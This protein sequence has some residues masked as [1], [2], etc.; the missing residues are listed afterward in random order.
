MYILISLILVLSY[1]FFSG[2]YKKTSYLLWSLL[3]VLYFSL[4]LGEV[5]GLPTLS[6]F[7]RMTRL[8]VGLY[9]PQVNLIPF[10]NGADLSTILNILAFIPLGVA[11]ST[12]W[13]G[14]EKI[15]PA[16]CYGLLFSLFIEV[17]QLFTLYRQTDVNDLIMN[18]LG[19]CLGWLLHHYFFKFKAQLDHFTSDWLLYPILVSFIIFFV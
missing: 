7:N 5:V 3:L 13:R 15:L 4:L 17:A 2:K 14:F 16:F 18:T 19:V 10:S 6:E 8:G 12:M 11:L 9:H 1:L